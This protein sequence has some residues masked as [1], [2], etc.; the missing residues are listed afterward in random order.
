MLM[1]GDGAFLVVSLSIPEIGRNVPT[2]VP[3]IGGLDRD[4]SGSLYYLIHHHTSLYIQSSIASC[5]WSTSM[6]EQLH[7]IRR[8]CGFAGFQNH[9]TPGKRSPL[10]EGFLKNTGRK[11]PQSPQPRVPSHQVVARY[12][13]RPTT[14]PWDVIDASGDHAA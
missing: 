9:P 4:L 1:T 6:Y 5:R 3:L 13:S 8:V 2:L 11:N 7:P 14:S 10:G 12:T